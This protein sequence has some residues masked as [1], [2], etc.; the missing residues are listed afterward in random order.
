MLWIA[1]SP[2]EFELPIAVEDTADKLAKRLKTSEGNIRSK[3]FRGANG[4]SCGY[5][6]V[7]VK[8]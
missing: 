8:L 7:T 3:R 4:K 5:R 1:V 6:V 2:D